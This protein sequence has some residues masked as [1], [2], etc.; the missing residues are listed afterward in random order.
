MVKSS[1]VTHSLLHKLIY[2]YITHTHTNIF[3]LY[4][5]G[6]SPFFLLLVCP[7]SSELRLFLLLVEMAFHHISFLFV[8]DFWATQ[9]MA[10][11]VFVRVGDIHMCTMHVHLKKKTHSKWQVWYSVN[12]VDGKVRERER[13]S[14]ML[15]NNETK[16]KSSFKRFMIVLLMHICHICMV[17]WHVL[18][19]LAATHMKRVV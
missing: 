9:C 11:S 8:G 14:K 6:L 16:H 19:M 10:Y 17:R 3:P 13:E 1:S 2:T 18:N 7:P 5:G 15:C 4:A 12:A